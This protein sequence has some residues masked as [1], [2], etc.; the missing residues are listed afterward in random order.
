LNEDEARAWLV[1]TQ[2]G[3]VGAESVRK[4][5]AAFGSAQMV[6]QAGPA[7]WAAVVGAAATK[8]LAAP[9][10][11]ALA[12]ADRTLAWCREAPT[13]R[14]LLTLADPAYPRG[15]L[16][17]AD[18]PALLYAL[19]DLNR[20]AGSAVAVVGSR[21]ATP[22]GLHHARQFAHDFG[23]TGL[24]VVS[25]LALGVDGAAHDG[26]LG[27]AGSTIAV[28]GTG[29]DRVYPRKHLD[30]ARRIAAEGLILSEFALGTPSLPDH[31]PRRNRILAGLSRGTVVIEASLRSG[32]LITAR[33][34]LECGRDVFAVPGSIASPQSRGCH[35]LIKEG[36]ALVE[37]AEDVLQA[38]AWSAPAGLAD[39]AGAE[40]SP[41]GPSEGS[42]DP[43]L[44]AMGYDPLTV[45]ALGARCGWPAD[46]L[47]ARL[48][49]LE[50]EGR[51]AR[52]PGGLLQRSDTG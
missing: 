37:T 33:M 23:V 24:T 19:G 29:L 2:T 25:G 5:L 34:A 51:V 44:E 32:S 42:T 52:L 1:L 35:R 21:D 7:A 20:L 4:L 38:F 12:L 9:R 36:A 16:N 26:A 47:Q 49:E 48:F 13:E 50:L 43:L 18:P 27:T 14:H 11:A 28:V 10:D 46:R 22:Q 41:A 8:A 40:A 17:T 31:F 3:G 45:D 15:L 30:L 6:L 39:S